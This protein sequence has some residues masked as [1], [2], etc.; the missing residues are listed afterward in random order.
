M[1]IGRRVFRGLVLLLLDEVFPRSEAGD[2]SPEPG[3]CPRRVSSVVWRNLRYNHDALCVVVFERYRL[4]GQL[5]QT[6]RNQTSTSKVT[7]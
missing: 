7:T 5:Q 4:Y 3:Q 6:S 2:F 1:C